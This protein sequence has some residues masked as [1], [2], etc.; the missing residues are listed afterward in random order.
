MGGTCT[1]TYD[2]VG[3]PLSSVAV[4]VPQLTDLDV[5]AVR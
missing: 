4:G 5:A 1:C 2:T 3:V